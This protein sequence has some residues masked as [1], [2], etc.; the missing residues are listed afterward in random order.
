MSDDGEVMQSPTAILDELLAQEDCII[1][2]P[3]CHAS[4]VWPDTDDSEGPLSPISKQIADLFD[5]SRLDL[6]QAVVE[7]YQTRGIKSLY[8]WQA[9]CLTTPGV[10]EGRNLVYCAPTSGGKT[11]VSE[12]LMLQ[13]LFRLRKR[14]IFV[15][16]Y[17]SVVSEK[18]AFLQSLCK[19]T[20]LS[21][22]FKTPRNNCNKQ[23]VPALTLPPSD[24]CALIQAFYGGSPASVKDPFDIA[25]C[26]LEKANALINHMVEEGQLAKLLGTLV[27]DELHLVGDASRGYLLE[28]FLSKVLFLAPEIQVLGLSATLPNVEDIAKWL[29]AV[30]YRTAY[31]PVPLQEYVLCGHELLSPDGSKVRTLSFE[32]LSPDSDSVVAA[33]WEVTRD[34]HSVLI[35]CS[36][37]VKCERTAELLASK[38][39]ASSQHHAS[40]REALVK[41]M[42]QQ[43]GGAD[44]T[45]EK[46]IPAGIAFHHSGLTTEERNVIERGYKSGHINAICATS[47]L[48]AGVNLPARRVVFQTPFMGNQLLDATQYKQMAGRA[49]RAGQGTVGESILISPANTKRQ[50][51][52]LV[53]Q[54]LPQVASCLR[55]ELRGLKR[56][57]LEVLC[58]VPQLGAGEDLIRFSLSTLLMTQKSAPDESLEPAQRYPEIAEA[59]KWLLAHDMARL[60]ERSNAYRATPLGHAVCASGLEPQ[61]GQ[62]LFQEMQ[63]ARS[64]ISLDTDLHV[65]YLVTP[66]SLLTVDWN[67]YKK[68]LCHL[69]A[70]ERRVA[71]R[72]KLR[73]DL[74]D[75]AQ[76]Q[77]RLPNSTL[78]SV[79]GQRIV[80]FYSAL[81][82][83]ALLHETPAALLLK[84]F[85]LSKG[86]LQQLQ[87]SAASYTH[88]VGVFCNRLQWYTLEALILSFQKRLALGVRL[89]LVPLMQ[90]PGMDCAVAHIA[91]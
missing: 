32:G 21:N 31:R 70:A 6:P 8:D 30:L 14:A 73:H 33:T 34:G 69:S 64:C 18:A 63:Q 84:K 5:L 37:K 12:V 67:V 87:Q 35:F 3:T 15:L 74:V 57:L 20:G 25:V 58:V 65:C 86:Q 59:V 48:A 83:W 53:Q 24:M 61:Q 2:S 41:Q 42:Q 38:L 10:Q 43:A 40:E 55:N 80:R 50:V 1:L 9:E 85:A 22:G 49:G 91:P 11:L 17:V 16:P 79:D 26:T 23:A 7:A 81:V 36:S 78:Q 82:L 44:P 75:Q 27:V 77:G 89:E 46:T 88:T 4:D 45:L 90:I 60:D 72:I 68:V 47:T 54:Q 28:I 71:Q 62:L 56:L 19:S 76:F 39:P 51:M 13:R 66:D 29:K 52:A